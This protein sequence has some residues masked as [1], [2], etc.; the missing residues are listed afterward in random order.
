[1]VLRLDAIVA[2]AAVVAARGS[3]NIAG[4]AVFGGNFKGAVLGGS[5]A[6]HDPIRGRRSKSERVFRGI[7]GWEG[8]KIAW[9]YLRLSNSGEIRNR[10]IFGVC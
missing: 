6:N 1:V 5:G 10:G 4:F 8:V 3:P 2:H 9:E 7:C